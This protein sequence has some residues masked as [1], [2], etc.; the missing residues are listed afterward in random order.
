MIVERLQA[1]GDAFFADFE[2]LRLGGA[3]HLKGRL[4]LVRGAGDGRRADAHQPAQQALVLDDADVFLDDRPARQ[5]LSQRGQVS[6][7]AYRFDLLVAGQ[8]VGQGD[9]VHGPLRVH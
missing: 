3:E 9:D 1:V 6:H 5:T 4:A 8:L 7:A 2:Q